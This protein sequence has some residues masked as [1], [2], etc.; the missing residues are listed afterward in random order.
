M[1]GRKPLVPKITMSAIAVALATAVAACGGGDDGGSSAKED[2]DGG[3]LV[4]GMFMP[5]TGPVAAQGAQAANGCLAAVHEINEAGGVLGKQLSCAE[6]DTQGSAT[7]AVPEVRS[8]LATTDNLFMALG[9]SS[10]EEPTVG[11]LLEDA[12]VVHF[13]PA[14]GAEFDRST[15]PYFYRL[16]PSDSLSMAA[17]ALHARDEGYKRVALVFTNTG[18]A[19]AGVPP[20]RAA[21]PE[22]GLEIVEAF[23]LPADAT[24]YQSAVSQLVSLDVDAIMTEMEPQAQATFLSQLKQ[25]D[26]LLPLITTNFSSITDWQKA[27]IGAIGEDEM[28]KYVVGVGLHVPPEGPGWEAYSKAL[29][30]A[31]GTDPDQY[32]ND[33]YA[34]THYDGVILS[35]LAATIADSTEGAVYNEHIEEIASPRSGKTVV[36]TFAEG[37]EAIEAGDDIQYVGAGGEL[38]LNEHHNV[39]GVFGIKRWDAKARSF[40][41]VKIVAQEDLNQIAE[42]GAGD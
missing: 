23:E 33:V 8:A 35:A 36:N 2:G 13:S 28:A 18:S 12:K 14:G 21:A 7:V 10:A 34:R 40:E 5:F 9:A 32:V 22:M 24:S 29:D 11:P 31:D 4:V 41:P 17:L 1:R 37:V 26:G 25:Q 42:I 30:A 27:V 16:T 3:E 20:L 6:T 19:Q 38:F 15:N 39:T